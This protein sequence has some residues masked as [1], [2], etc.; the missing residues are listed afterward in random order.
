M[1]PRF[2]AILVCML[3]IATCLSVSGDIKKEEK[4]CKFEIL[5][6]PTEQ[7]P[8]ADNNN[9]KKEGLE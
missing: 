4:N 3:L 8:N 1:K 9:Y 6:N 7:N 2:Y 5:T